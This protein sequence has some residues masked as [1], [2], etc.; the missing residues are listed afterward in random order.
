MKFAVPLLLSFI[1]F[2][3]PTATV[4][5]GIRGSVHRYLSSTSNI[6]NLQLCATTD[7]DVNNDVYFW[8][9]LLDSNENNMGSCLLTVPDGTAAGQSVCCDCSKNST[10]YSDD[11]NF[12]IS[13]PSVIPYPANTIC[14]LEGGSGCPNYD[15]DNNHLNFNNFYPTFRNSNGVGEIP[16]QMGSFT[17]DEGK[18]NCGLS[19]EDTYCYGTLANIYYHAHMG[20]ENCLQAAITQ[21][22]VG[23]CK[24]YGYK[25]LISQC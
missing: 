17:T 22:E 7:S 15:M 5:S 14:G 11:Y 3:L 12:V 2:A 10:T 19:D 23:D 21:T 24:A 4:A 16:V 9:A 13:D 25:C 18:N 8:L 1:N 6:T 20:S